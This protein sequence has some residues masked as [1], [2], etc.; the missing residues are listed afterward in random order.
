MEMV[1]EVLLGFS[2]IGGRVDSMDLNGLMSVGGEGEGDKIR[3]EFRG[4]G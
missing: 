1:V 4:D 2:V 3:C